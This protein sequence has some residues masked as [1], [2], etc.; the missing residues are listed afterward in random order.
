MEK[1]LN[2]ARWPAWPEASG[3]DQKHQTQ[4]DQTQ[5][6]FEDLGTLVS[7]EGQHSGVQFGREDSQG[8]PTQ[9]GQQH[10]KRKKVEGQQ[11]AGHKYPSPG[12][13]CQDSN[14]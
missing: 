5:T 13:S 7:D 4:P 12:H 14:G 2:S 1:V 11:E 8:R 6:Q 3:H 10:P 9:A